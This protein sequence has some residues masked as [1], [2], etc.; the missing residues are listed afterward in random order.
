MQMMNSSY[1]NTQTISYNQFP[2]QQNPG[3]V[4]SFQIYMTKGTEELFFFAGV[5]SPIGCGVSCTTSNNGGVVVGF[6][7]NTAFSGGAGRTGV[8]IYLMDS[9]GAIVAAAPFSG[10]SAWETVT[11]TYT[12]GTTNTWVVT[13]KGVSVIT[14][15]DPSN[16]SW[17]SSAG[18]YWGFG[19]RDGGATGN[20]YITQ[21]NLFL[22]KAELLC[23][24][25]YFNLFQ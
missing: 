8:G 12:K 18:N 3:F 22:G 21:V 7:V 4:C 16:P 23:N 17:V 1:G 25:K 9:T 20:F 6:D 13:W 5:S 14:Y 10:N 15:S 24:P 2:I 11:I 19:G